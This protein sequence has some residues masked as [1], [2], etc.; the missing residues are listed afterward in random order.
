MKS[1]LNTIKFLLLIV[2]AGTIISS[3]MKQPNYPDYPVIKLKA[4]IPEGDS[5]KLV[6][7]FTDGDGDI[8]LFENDTIPPY[9]ANLFLKYYEQREGQFVE[10][11]P[12]IPFNYRIPDISKK[13]RIKTLEGEIMVRINYYYDFASPYDTIKYAAYIMD[14]ALNKSNI[15]ETDPIV[16]KK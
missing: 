6:F 13:G 7:E 12:I 10:I 15:I 4:F 1:I 8:G 11:E 3:C 16:V 5:A 9:D 14:R 2:I